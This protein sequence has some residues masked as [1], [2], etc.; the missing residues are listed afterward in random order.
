MLKQS[1]AR[2]A[3]RA[4]GTCA[5][6][7]DFGLFARAGLVDEQ[8]FGGERLDEVGREAVVVG[9]AVRRVAEDQVVGGALGR[10]RLEDVSRNDARGGDAK[11]LEVPVDG[12]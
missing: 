5:K 9:V 7:L 8:S 3:V 1:K 4:G 11:L 2:G 10:K 6:S 12:A